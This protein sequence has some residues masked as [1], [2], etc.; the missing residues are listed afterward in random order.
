MHPQPPVAAPGDHAAADHPH[1]PTLGPRV[2]NVAVAT[3]TPLVGRPTAPTAVP[4]THPNITGHDAGPRPPSRP[5][6]IPD[7]EAAI[8]APL[9][10]LDTVE[11][12]D[13][14]RG[15]AA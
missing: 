12:A 7:L 6:A 1:V 14:T 13:P 4:T 3:R 15:V 11:L 9:I 10:G 5:P 2:P 8:S